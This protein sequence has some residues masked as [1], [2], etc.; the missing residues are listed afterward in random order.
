MGGSVVGVGAAGVVGDV[1]D[2]GALGDLALEGLLDALFHGHVGHAAALA[3]L[4]IAER[5]IP[6]DGRFK[7]KA[8][9]WQ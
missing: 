1:H 9:R 7:I 6:Q 8:I 5:R 3:D 4:D 2:G